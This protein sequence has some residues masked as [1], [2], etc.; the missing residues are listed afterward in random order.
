MKSNLSRVIQDIEALSAFNS[1]PGSGV[2]RL[3][4]TE[5]DRMA[6]EYIKKQMNELALGVWEDG[7][8]NLFGRKEG[9]NPNAPVIMLGSHYDSVTNGGPFDGVAG[10]AVALEV[11]RVFKE[12]QIENYHP[13][14]IVAM[15]DEEGVRFGTGISNS[16]VMAGLMKEEELDRAKDQDGITLRE[17]ME[18]FGVTPDLESAKRPVGSIKAFLEL[19]IEQG[20]ILENTGQDL[21]LVETIVG[22]DKYEVVFKG[23][24]G[25]AGTTPMDNRNDALIAASEVI[26]AVNRIVKDIGDRT[27]GTVGQLS[28]SPNAPNVIPGHAHLSIDVRSTKEENMKEAYARLVKEVEVIKEKADVEIMISNGLYIPPVN[29]SEAL[30]RLMESV[31]QRL[32]Y[33]SLRMNSGA[34]HDAMA[35]A[36]VAP[37][38]LV[39]VPS[40]DGLSHH[41]DEWTDYED[42][43]KGIELMLHTVLELSSDLAGR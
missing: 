19:H 35:M 11:V 42:L 30:I 20:P 2:T 14:E 6:R 25:H 4:F 17:A 18:I 13:V 7:Y 1:T 38:S 26:L 39:F 15:N 16:R 8:G 31:C 23:K 28:L 10:L 29:M 41:P 43:E 21:G 40:K 3:A 12:S 24:S 33:S 32:G 9:T 27:V 5:E 37:T 36:K 22:L 34:G